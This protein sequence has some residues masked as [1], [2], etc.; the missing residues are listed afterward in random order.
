MP[1]N[2]TRLSRLSTRG[3]AENPTSAAYTAE[4][5]QA[6]LQKAGVIAQHG[7]RFS[8]MGSLG[9]QADQNFDAVL[10]LDPSNGEAQFYKADVMAHWALVLNKGQE[11]IHRFSDSIDQQET[12]PR[13]PQFAQTYV[14]LG[15]Q[16]QKRGQ[17]KYAAATWQL[18]AAEF[19]SD[20]DLQKRIRGQ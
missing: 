13:Q 5:G 10:K 18:G 12:M 20:P 16:Y 1:A 3:A 2:W 15:N 17:P 14:W 6:R 7:G 19:R 4:L 9:M 8:E 11:I